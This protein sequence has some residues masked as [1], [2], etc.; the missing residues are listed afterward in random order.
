[1]FVGTRPDPTSKH[2]CSSEQVKQG[3]ARSYV[4]KLPNSGV[5]EDDFPAVLACNS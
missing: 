3:Q 1:V 5:W 4:Y 2:S